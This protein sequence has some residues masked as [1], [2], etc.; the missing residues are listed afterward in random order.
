MRACLASA[1][2]VLA[3][4]SAARPSSPPIAVRGV[5]IVHPATGA[6]E[7]DAT[8]VI[9]GD[10]IVAAGAGARAPEGATIIDGSG[11]F[12]IPGLVDAHVHFFQSGNL[13]T[14]PDAADLQQAV[15]YAREVARNKARLP[16]TFAVWLASGVTSVVDVGGPFWNFDVRA[17]A[18]ATLAPR[19]QVAGP[20]ISFVAD[21]PLELD[22]PPIIKVS[23]VDD[24]RALAR[25]ELQRKPDFLKVW[26]IREK[27]DDLAAKEAMVRAAAEEAHAAGIR[28]AV[29]ATELDSAKAALRA[30]ADVL[31]HSVFND[32][33]DADFLALARARRAIYTPT[34]FVTM[35]YPLALSGQWKPTP[36]EERFADPEVLAGLRLDAVPREALP[37]RVRK[38]LADPP[39]V[40]PNAVALANLR[41]VRDA[42]IDIAL[43]TDAGNIGTV[44]GPSVFR[45]AALM[46]QAGLTPAEVLRAATVGGARVLG[47]EA[48]LGDLAP[49]RLADLV[50]LDADPL[51]DV[52]NLARIHLVVRAGRPLEPAALVAPLHAR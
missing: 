20:L 26:F 16:A 4:C 36:E 49:G 11:R 40:T 13:F 18:Q 22:D 51:Q 52:A 44:H 32:P 8:I 28:L 31:V 33:V 50:L 46:A 14:R 24:V 9:D 10:R 42:G 6:V 47:M 41:A 15:P 1:I 35:G 19:V 7:R 25:R 12:A 3:S 34:L 23:S 17:A 30:G 43:G 48:Q 39:T 37:E 38:R 27:G 5:A 29:H 2:L 45:E 21:P